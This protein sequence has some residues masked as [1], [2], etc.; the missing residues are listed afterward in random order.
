M[1]KKIG[2]LIITLLLLQILSKGVSLEL[3]W[4][5][6]CFFQEERRMDLW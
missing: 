2:L 4:S 6:C 5:R 3:H 1:Q